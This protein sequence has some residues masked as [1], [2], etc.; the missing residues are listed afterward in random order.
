VRLTHVDLGATGDIGTKQAII[1]RPGYIEVVDV[2]APT[3]GPDQVRVR[4][5]AV[6]ICGSDL[7]ALAG[8]HPFIDLPVVPGHE[9]SG[10]VDELG[11]SEVAFEVGDRVLLEPNLVCGHCFY[12]VSGRYNLCE[13]LK[14]VGCQTPGGMAEMFVASSSRF[15]A[16]PEGMTWTEAALVEPLSTATHAIRIAG[17]LRGANVVVLGAG[18]IGLFTM[19]AARAAGASAVVMSDPLPGKRDRA[20]HLGA[21]HAFDP[22]LPDFVQAIRRS[23]THRPDVVFDCV[24]NQASMDQAIALA[25]KGGTVVV[26]G[27]AR[28]QVDIPLPIVQDREIRIQGSAMYIAEDVAR[29]I[30][31]ISD[32]SVDVNRIVTATFPLDRVAEAFA[33]A[34]SGDHIKVQVLAASN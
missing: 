15:H 13:E 33:A 20:V 11:S 29:A 7:H 18:S 8:H 4:S 21:T 31:L 14:V 12:C 10:I 17:D 30:Q 19:T 32:R 25:E 6:G 16:V 28:G 27:V 34:R 3:P 9:V 26:I 5:V 23:L 22:Q 2:S 1:Q 24:A